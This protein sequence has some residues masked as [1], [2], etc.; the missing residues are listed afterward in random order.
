MITL[1]VVLLQATR[2]QMSPNSSGIIRIG[3]YDYEPSLIWKAETWA[4]FLIDFPLRSPNC[5]V[6]PG[7]CHESM[8]QAWLWY[9]KE[10]L[11]NGLTSCLAASPSRWLAVTTK[12][13]WIWKSCLTHLKIMVWR[14]YMAR[15][16]K[17]DNFW[18]VDMYY[19]FWQL[20]AWRPNSDVSIDNSIDNKFEIY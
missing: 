9:V 10:L 8:Y 15:F 16:M 20:A 17:I 7:W 19:W 18:P 13:F 5:W 4:H 12:Q 2:G 1:A 6:S 3:S 11:R 14:S